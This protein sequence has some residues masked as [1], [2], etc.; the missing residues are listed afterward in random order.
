MRF[1]IVSSALLFAVSALAAPTELVA[2]Q[3][4][5]TCGNNYYSSGQVSNAVN[6]G[7]N[8][9]ANG[10]QVG[11][12][13]YPH[14]YNNYEGFDFPVSG[15]YQEFPIKESGVYTG[16]SPG[17]DRVVFNTDGEYAGAITHTGASGN[18]FVGCSGTN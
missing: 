2:R 17:A 12:G 15:P 3:S 14:T 1:S 7:Y 6:Q 4:S 5:T 8:Y 9:Y 10:E 11:S 16:G 13:D 18:N